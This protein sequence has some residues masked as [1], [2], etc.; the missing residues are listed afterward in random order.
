M[1]VGAGAAVLLAALIVAG[2]PA[3]PAATAD[4]N[5]GPNCAGW[6]GHPIPGS[7]EWNKADL[8]NLQCAAE[9]LRILQESPAVAAAKAAN[10][11]AADGSFVGM[12]TP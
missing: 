9:G 2:L 10:A 12:S 5:T 3:S 11:A 6:L 4:N 1:R 8:N 7:A